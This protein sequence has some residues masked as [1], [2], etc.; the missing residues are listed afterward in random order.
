M[1]A[2]PLSTHFVIEVDGTFAGGIGYLRFE[3]ERRLSGE[4]GY[5]L[6]RRFWGRGIATAALR[7]VA[8]LAFER[9][10]ILRLE[11]GAYSN[12]PA[13]ARVLE[14][15]GFVR[16]GVLRSAVIKGDEILDVI[17]YAKIRS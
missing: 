12:N 15:C 5:W 10:P 2:H 6:G 14:K 4:I 13:S 7:K 1:S 8:D 17:M 11:A 3:A 16:E 9:E